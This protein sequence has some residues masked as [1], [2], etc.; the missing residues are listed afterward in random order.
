MN[1]RVYWDEKWESPVGR[2]SEDL[3]GNGGYLLLFNDVCLYMY[4]SGNTG[5][6]Q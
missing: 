4:D 3:V 2:G 5:I 1:V 6:L